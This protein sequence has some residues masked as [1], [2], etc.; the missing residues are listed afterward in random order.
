MTS[1]SLPDP[2]A[3]GPEAP[4]CVSE[5]E[6]AV[7]HP[8]ATA[9]S[10]AP[11]PAAGAAPAGAAPRRALFANA[12]L[13]ALGDVLVKA[14]NFFMLPLYTR[15]LTP[16]DYGTLALVQQAAT[17]AALFF[18]LGTAGALQ[19][20]Y[21]TYEKVPGGL[22]RLIGSLATYS[23]LVNLLGLGLACLV[24]DTV[25]RLTLV[26]GEGLFFPYM[27]LG[28]LGAY[29]YTYPNL[30]LGVYAME[31]APVRY[32]T[33]R[34]V[35]FALSFSFICFGLLY[36]KAGA[37][38][39]LGGQAAAACLIWLYFLG[40]T[41]RR[42]GFHWDWAILRQLL[43]YGAKLLPYSFLCAFLSGCDRY[44]LERFAPEGLTAVGLFDVGQ[45]F[46]MPLEVAL[47]AFGQSFS[48]RGYRLLARGNDAAREYCSRVL[49]GA[50]LVVSVVV[51]L[52]CL[53]VP[54]VIRL[55]L[56]AS[57]SQAAAVACA[58]L[59]YQLCRPIFIVLTLPVFYHS[60]TRLWRLTVLPGLFVMALDLALVPR[61]GA[62]GAAMGT[63][64]S[65]L[66][67]LVLAQRLA[68]RHYVPT[69]LSR[70]LAG[71]LLGF[72]LAYGLDRWVEAL[73]SGYALLPK[74]ALLGLFAVVTRFVG[75]VDRARLRTL[76]HDLNDDPLAGPAPDGNSVAPAPASG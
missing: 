12:V 60:P 72:S 38:G 20:F 33:Y 14:I 37:V 61:L 66:F 2:K 47:F 73:D 19:R 49:P 53:F 5:A 63:V 71:A 8:A 39:L 41:A 57:Y 55:L 34:L 11:P 54:P 68:R 27:A 58:V 59:P 62:L 69:L 9:A 24:G 10:P 28:L 56:P 36:L 76:W 3:F 25:C 48:P 4:P 13:Y 16:A 30:N 70:P 52:A 65:G 21:P 40:V 44:V 22:S 29:L 26:H 31:E 75:G 7:A 43:G 6:P 42:Y 17:W 50:F 46:V 23:A 18:G 67:V 51:L 35:T 32:T 74:F 15:V 1:S 64:L 45:K